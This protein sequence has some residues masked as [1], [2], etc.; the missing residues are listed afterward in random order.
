MGFDELRNT[1]RGRVLTAGD[2]DFDA[3]ARPWSLAVAQPVAAVVV[4]ADAA[5]AAAVVRYAASAGRRVV[6]QPTG[7]GAA[8]GV[9]D[10]ILLRTA[11]LDRLE[12]DPAARVA[13]AGAGVPWGRVQAAAAEH[14]LTGL[15]GSN[16]VVG[17]TGYT[18][19]GGLGWFARK[20]GFASNAVRAFEI[21]D[22]EG[23]AARVTA[24]GDPDLFWALSGGGGDFAVVT[25]L[26]FELFPA[27]GLYGGRIVWPAER[28]QEV[29]EAFRALTSQAP[30]EL[31]AW[32]QRFQF[33]QAPEMVAVD[34]AYLGDPAEGRALTA[35]LDGLGGAVSDQRAAMS[36]ADLGAITAEPSD[37]SPAISRAELLPELT[38]EAEKIIVGESVAPLVNIQVRQLGGALARPAAGARGAMPEQYAV[39]L[40]GLGLPQLRDA[41]HAK[42]NAVVAELGGQVSGRKPFTFLAPGESAAAAFDAATLD[43]LRAVKRDRDPS[44]VIRS[45]FP[46]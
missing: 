30:D 33:P 31:S 16:P 18:L 10:A 11:A 5:D 20:H 19:G 2:D 41:V 44:G 21:V 34:V 38:P 37:P 17:V 15:A 35:V 3:A 1:V 28:L 13:R 32:F 22:A 9:D 29:W 39:Y 43:R 4:A 24:D 6:T 12:I 26:E 14:G 40:L 8:G 27:P 42:L 23:R 25:G 46:V 45:N 36:V 7:H